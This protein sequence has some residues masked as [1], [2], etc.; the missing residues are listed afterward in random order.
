MTVLRTSVRY[1]TDTAA[2]ALARR[3]TW[4]V[5]FVVVGVA[6]G[7]LCPTEKYTTPRGSSLGAMVT[8]ANRA[9]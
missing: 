2:A 6:T 7:S 8:L 5:S 9:V 4:R 3:C 1:W